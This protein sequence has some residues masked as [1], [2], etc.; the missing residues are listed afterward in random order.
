MTRSFG[1]IGQPGSVP[2]P[3]MADNRM[4]K[5]RQGYNE[6]T[7]SYGYA[8]KSKILYARPNGNKRSK[9]NTKGVKS[10]QV[11]GPY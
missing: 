4:V 1:E 7:Q 9:T 6:D 5:S 8:P 2:G 11:V 10:L 3:I